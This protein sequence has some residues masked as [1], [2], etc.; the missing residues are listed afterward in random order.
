MTMTMVMMIIE[1]M[2]IMINSINNKNM[3][4]EI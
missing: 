2:I 4:K 3:T 1:L